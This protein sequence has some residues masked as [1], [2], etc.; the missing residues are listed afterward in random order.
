MALKIKTNN[1]NPKDNKTYIGVVEDNKD[2]KKNGRCRI[3]VMDVFDGKNDDGTYRIKTDEIPWAFPWK[4]LNGNAFNIPDIGKIVIVVFEEGN[5]ETPEYISADHYNVNLEKKLES[6]T[7]EE[8]ISMKSLIFDHK[9]Q[10][11]VNDTEGLKMDYKFNNVNIKDQSINVNLKD[12][13]AKLNL[14]TENATQRA[15]LGDTFTNWL[16]ELLNIF[17]SG[18]FLGNLGAPLAPAPSL[19]KHIQLYQTIKD[20]KILSKNVFIVDN[21]DVK[22]LEKVNE[23]LR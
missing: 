23:T 11:Y 4:D 13:F 2:P 7:N 14:G 6:L 15:I 1:P 9:T 22:V 5:P 12:N 3:R 10:I 8:Y 21:E 17:M 16:D 20:P 18:A 19:V